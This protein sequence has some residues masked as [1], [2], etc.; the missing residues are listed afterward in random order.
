MSKDDV[1][2]ALNHVDESNRTTDIYIAKD[3]KMVDDVQRKVIAQL[4]KVEVKVLK[5]IQA[6]NETDSIAA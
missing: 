2:L 4:K 1:A 5:K 3:W 6:K